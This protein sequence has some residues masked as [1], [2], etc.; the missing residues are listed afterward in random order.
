MGVGAGGLVL[1]MFEVKCYPKIS[2]ESTLYGTLWTLGYIL[3]STESNW[4]I[5]IKS[6]VICLTS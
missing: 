5:L 1:A 2:E 4:R 3:K 6:D